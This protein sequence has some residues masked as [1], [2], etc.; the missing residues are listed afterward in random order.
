[1]AERFDQ[2]PIRDLVRRNSIILGGLGEELGYLIELLCLAPGGEERVEGDNRA[3]GSQ[4][5]HVAEG[6]DGAAR[7]ACTA[8]GDDESGDEG[9]LGEI[10]IGFLGFDECFDVGEAAG[11]GEATDGEIEDV[12]GGDG[13]GEAVGDGGDDGEGFIGV[14]VGS[15][16]GFRL[17]DGDSLEDWKWSC[18]GG[19]EAE[20]EKKVTARGRRRE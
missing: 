17:R 4:A 9:L 2:Y 7:Q 8:I 13:V 15:E 20:M 11:F 10:G 3:G 16:S 5:I 19:E 18:R 14:L 6:V 1:M 12:A